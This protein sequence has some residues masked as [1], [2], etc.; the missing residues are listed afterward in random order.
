MSEPTLHH[1]RIR[2]KGQITLPGKIRTLLGVEEG[3]DLIF[4]VEEDNRVSIERGQLIPA[5]QSWFWSERWQ[6]MEREA[7]AD[8]AAG[9]TRRFDSVQAALDFLHSTDDPGDAAD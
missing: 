5:G 6:R 2:P 3:D 9:K 4:R 8:I 7:Q 1:T